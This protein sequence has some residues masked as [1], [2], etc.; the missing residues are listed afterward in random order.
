MELD[1]FARFAGT[2]T[3]GKIG[4]VRRPRFAALLVQSELINHGRGFESAQSE[5][6]PLSLVADGRRLS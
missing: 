2:H 5:V 1:R 3:A 6:Q 4:Y